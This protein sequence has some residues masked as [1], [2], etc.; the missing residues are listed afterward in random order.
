MVCNFLKLF[1]VILEIMYICQTL[2]S[3]HPLQTHTTVTKVQ[4][5]PVPTAQDPSA[6]CAVCPT[7]VLEPW[8]PA[9]VCISSC[10]EADQ[11]YLLKA[12]KTFIRM[13]LKINLWLAIINSFANYSSI[14]INLLSFV[15]DLLLWDDYLM[16]S[17]VTGITGPIT[18][19]T[20]IPFG[21]DEFAKSFYV[22]ICDLITKF[23][24]I[25]SSK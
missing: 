4:E 24:Y 7:L 9:N 22:S 6:A 20:D 10:L 23:T 13:N 5:Q 15:E 11:F 21:T 17:P 19:V 14:V 12:S 1:L 25:V 16:G 18:P 8:A 2:M 3:A